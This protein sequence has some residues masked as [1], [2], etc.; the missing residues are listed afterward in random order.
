MKRLSIPITEDF[1]QAVKTRAAS[2]GVPLAEVIRR[3]LGWWLIGDVEIP[4][5]DDYRAMEDALVDY[6]AEKING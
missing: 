2:D 5:G 1:H 6:Y 3:L 4:Q